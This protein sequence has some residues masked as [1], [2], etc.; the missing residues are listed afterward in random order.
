MS[1]RRK[2]KRRTTKINQKTINK[3]AVRT[4][5]SILTINISGLNAPKT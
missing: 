4:Y 1:K 5:L 3:M 2:V